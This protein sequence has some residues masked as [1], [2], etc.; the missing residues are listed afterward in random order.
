MTNDNRERFVSLYVNHLLVKSVERQFQAFSRGFHKVSVNIFQVNF[1]EII[2]TEHLLNG[3]KSSYHSMLICHS[4]FKL[5]KVF[6][7]SRSV[8]GHSNE[9]KAILSS[10]FTRYCLICCTRWF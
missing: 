9:M 8:C 2:S 5:C 7:T 10:T 1:M 6:S 4:L 3:Q